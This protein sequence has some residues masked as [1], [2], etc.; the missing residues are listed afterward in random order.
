[1]VVRIGRRIYF[2][3]ATGNILV[4]TGERSGSVVET[5]VTQDVETYTVLSER[6]RET[7]DAIE[8]MYG[9]F[10]Q[11]FAECNGY[12]V[13]PVTKKVEFSYPDPNEPETPPVFRESLSEEI[14]NLKI[15]LGNTQTQ[16]FNTDTALMGFMDHYFE[17][18][19]V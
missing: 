2:D 14:K 19:G 9:E 3:L 5:T 10:A 7:F 1:M 16:S 8:L 4:D 13:N 17:N 12:R 15:D 11:D 6:K 18:G